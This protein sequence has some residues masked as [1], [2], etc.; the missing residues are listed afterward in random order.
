MEEIS[1]HL[2]LVEDNADFGNM[3]Q[4]Y[5][6]ICGYKVTWATDGI[7]GLEKI[8]TQSFD[9]CVLDVMMPQMDGFTL[10]EKIRQ[11]QKN[12]QIP[13][14]FLTAKKLKEDRLKGLRLGDDYMV[15]PFEVEE[16]LLRI[17]NLLKRINSS[18]NHTSQPS[19]STTTSL[20]QI[21]SYQFDIPNLSLQSPVNQYR[22]T[23][24]ESQLLAYLIQ[25]KNQV[26]KRDEIMTRFWEEDDFFTRRSMNVFI[27]R[28]RKYLKDDPALSIESLRGVGIVLKEN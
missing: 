19:N 27:S 4:Q 25:H 5:L 21:G 26:V 28:L 10:A 3:L 24:K 12:T 11:E 14:L 2:L 17:Q 6:N 13:I 9:L 7:A 8:K 22:L 1:Q 23:E 18:A 15:K 16:L 20:L